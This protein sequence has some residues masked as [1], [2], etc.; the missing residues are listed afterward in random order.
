MTDSVVAAKPASPTHAAIALPPLPYGYTELQP[1]LSEATMRTHHDK[2][3][4][5]YVETLN[6]LLSE[7]SS[8]VRSLED[9][10]RDAAGSGP[11]GRFNNAAQAWNHGFFWES[12]TPRPTSIGGMLTG[13][14]MEFGGFDTLRTRF[15]AE[16]T[17]HFA[18]GWVWLVAKGP[19]LSVIS[20]HDAGTVLTEAGLTPLLVCDLW[21]HAYYLDYRQDR[22]VWLAAWWDKLAN[23]VF[24][25]RQYGA[26]LG[27]DGGWRYPTEV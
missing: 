4:A 5:R 10:V 7:G 13:A 6:R 17:T 11:S 19:T 16:G 26:A 2:H 14:V 21:E 8:P 15:I 27:Q 23:W 25:Q 3:H 12:M 18:S 20:T 1:V 9:I 24:A 22:A